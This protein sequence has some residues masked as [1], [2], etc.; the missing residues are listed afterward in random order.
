[1]KWRVEKVWNIDLFFVPQQH[2]FNNWKDIKTE[3][4]NLP[5]EKER[6]KDN[7]KQNNLDM[8]AAT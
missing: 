4:D 2:R 3:E 7:K 6:K 5:L 1:M 8:T